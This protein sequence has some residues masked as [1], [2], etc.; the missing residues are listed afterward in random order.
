MKNNMLPDFL[1]RSIFLLFFSFKGA[2]SPFVFGLRD[3]K[4]SHLFFFCSSK[5]VEKERNVW[6]TFFTINNIGHFCPP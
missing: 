5:I 2:K 4:I 1:S 3:V 6:Y